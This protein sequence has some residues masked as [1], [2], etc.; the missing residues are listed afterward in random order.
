[1]SGHFHD[2]PIESVVAALASD[3]QNGIG[4]PEARARLAR[5]GGNVIA[6]DE[7]PTK[8]EILKA[9]ILN[10]IVGVL[11][12]AAILSIVL[13]E[14]IDFGVIISIVIL[15]AVVGFY[16]EYRA[17]RALQLLKN[18]AAPKARVIRGGVSTSVSATA[19]VPGDL[20]ELEPGDLVPADARIVWHAS[21]RTNESALTGESLPIEKS[22]A[23]SLASNT[24]L[25]DRHCCVYLGTS[26]SAGR[27]RAI[28]FGT[29]AETEL[30]KIVT[31][32]REAERE[33]TSLQEDLGQ[34]GKVLLIVCALAILAVFLAGVLRGIVVSEMFLTAVSLAVAAIPEGLPAIV[35]ITLAIG[36][37]RMLKRHVL[38]RRLASV[39]TLGCASVICA[40]KTGTITKNELTVR[41]VVPAGTANA[42]PWNPRDEGVRVV[43]SAALCCSNARAAAAGGD[44]TEAAIVAAAAR[45]GVRDGDFDIS[46]P[47]VAEAP[48]DSDRRRMS[49]LHKKDGAAVLFVKGAHEFV[50]EQCS[51]VLLKNSEVE[52]DDARSS[53]LNAQ[54]LRLSN[55]GMRVLAVAKRDLDA[56]ALGSDPAGFER[57]LTFLGFLAMADTPRPEVRDAVYECSRA[58]I[59]T[60]L[61][62]GD[63]AGTATAIAREVGIFHDGDIAVTGAEL[64]QLSDAE[65]E[66]EV[67]KITVYARLAPEQKLKIVRAWKRRGAVVAMTGDGV[68]DAPAIKEADIGIAMGQTGTDVA[69]EA[70]DLIVT[71]DHFASIVAGVEEGRAVYANIRRALLCL[72]AGNLSEVALVGAATA[73]GLP[74][75]LHPTQILWMNLVTDGPPALA[76]AT[77]P[78]SPDEMERPPRPRRSRLLDR[79]TI[80]NAVFQGFALYLA[81]MLALVYFYNGGA[82]GRAVS[83]ARMQTGVFCTVVVSQML[84]CFSFRNDRKSAFTL[85]IKG[86]TRLAVAIFVSI[87]LQAAICHFVWARPVF[88]T[89]EMSLDDWRAIALF[90]LIP[91][92]IVEIRKFW[93]RRSGK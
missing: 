77:E 9:Q 3:A 80:F 56:T 81:A 44:P 79:E 33:P 88:H 31:L 29:G 72:F 70:A 30:G 65:L 19:L 55:L 87:A 62:T 22:T 6:G 47:R 74:V 48:F 42:D 2:D 16:Q 23:A 49:T 59:R 93:I 38:L 58:G 51:R 89:I 13:R 1:M 7:G 18:L 90:S 20:I 36:V 4:E 46:M 69:R 40:D 83:E 37:Q 60:V 71:D 11:L 73:L 52:L 76:L 15:N 63:H 54:A 45:A 17:E 82:G 67:D 92:T 75:P 91:I 78:V 50:L 12:V 21:L 68:N 64:Q 86:N 5:L 57:D 34:V 10:P 26:V 35:T 25:G 14:W 53:A 66:N 8:I 24:S 32:V 84:N 43:L 41:D 61:L 27:A 85:G 28:V 39:E